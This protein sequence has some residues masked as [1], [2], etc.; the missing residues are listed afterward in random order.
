[1]G[2][3]PT[4]PGKEPSRVSG[5]DPNGRARVPS[6]NCKL[7]AVDALEVGAGLNAAAE[8]ARRVMAATFIINI[9]VIGVVVA[10]YVFI[11][12]G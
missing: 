5:D 6:I 3:K 8:P 1:M 11:C 12:N 7:R 10:E 2:S 9:R 4:S